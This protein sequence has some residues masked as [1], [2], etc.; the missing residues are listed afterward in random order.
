MPEVHV[1]HLDED[2]SE[3]ELHHAV[4]AAKPHHR[5]RSLL[6]IGLEIILITTGVSL[7]LAGEQWR[8]SRHH[9][10][11]ART[12]LERFRSEFQANRKEVLRVMEDHRKE[13]DGLRGYLR[14]NN[15]TLIAHMIDHAKPIPFP[16]PRAVT[17][18]A[19]VDFSAWDFALATQSLAYIDP[20]LVASMSSAYRLQQI[21]I[22]AHRSIQQASYQMTDI[23]YWLNGVT[24]YFGDAVL[25]ERL[26]LKRYDDILPRL[27]KALGMS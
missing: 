7:G 5:W 4:A 12:S 17:D 9:Q 18:S 24:T 13:L 27:E 20:E 22:D 21:Y 8:E 25:Y 6:K 14:E 2:E 11:L 16:L 10:E 19:G 23:V 26:L 1:P 15:T 3:G